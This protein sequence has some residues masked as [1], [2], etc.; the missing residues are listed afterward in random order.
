MTLDRAAKLNAIDPPM[1]LELRE[2]LIALGARMDVGAVVVTGSGERSFSAGADIAEMA[3]MDPTDARSFAQLGQSVTSLIEALPQPVLA[4]VNGVA[5]GGGCELVLACDLRVCSD[6]ARFAQ[7]EI[8]LGVVPGW[9]GTQR[10]VRLCGLEFA[11]RMIYTGETVD[12]LD[13][14]AHGLVSAVLPAAELHASAR[15][16]AARL[17]GKD[18]TALR[19]AKELTRRAPDLELSHGLAFE[20]DLFALSFVAPGQAELMAAFVRR[21]SASIT[22]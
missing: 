21:K 12:A 2:A 16:L 18:V 4:A 15:E 20:A 19:F 7:P 11:R 13:A 1:L 5:F 9:G 22:A 10:L 3:S 8:D 6:G 14:L 17:A